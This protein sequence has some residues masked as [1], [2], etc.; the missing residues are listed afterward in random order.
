MPAAA[1]EERGRN[2]ARPGEPVVA[3]TRGEG[4]GS[5]PF[6]PAR[7]SP[8]ARRRMRIGGR[9][10]PPLLLLAV[11]PAP[12]LASMRV[13]SFAGWFSTPLSHSAK[14]REALLRRR[15]C[16]YRRFPVKNGCALG[17]C[18]HSAAF[19]RVRPRFTLCF[20]RAISAASDPPPCSLICLR[21]RL[22]RE[23]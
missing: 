17:P 5:G 14:L 19:Y 2:L 11:F 22:K 9:Q 6:A 18:S 21:H 13:A 15:R 7:P 16:C 12:P 3:S 10:L 8:R 4:R 20:A 1:A 23:R